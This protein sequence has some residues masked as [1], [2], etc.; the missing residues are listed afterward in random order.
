L[1]RLAALEGKP[2]PRGRALADTLGM[3]PSAAW[4]FVRRMR[5]AGVLHLVSPVRLRS[6]VCDCITDV[7][8]DTS[9]PAALDLFE[10]RIAA[11]PS[12][13]VAARVTGN[14]DYRLF[15][16]HRDYRSANDWSRSLEA[17]PGVTRVRTR[18][19]DVILDRSGVATAI[20]GSDLS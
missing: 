1:R 6:E 7:Q 12:V 8:V 16:R 11:D 4:G 20:L 17:D 2:L 18:L 10:S 14:C 19:C 13:L 3:Q 5:R 15:S 9:N